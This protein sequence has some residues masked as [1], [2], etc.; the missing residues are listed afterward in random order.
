[1]PH[2]RRITWL[3][4]K[5]CNIHYGWQVCTLKRPQKAYKERINV[6]G[7]GFSWLR[8]E[9]E[10]MG[11]SFPKSSV[12]CMKCISSTK[13]HLEANPGQ[14]TDEQ[15]K[16]NL[17]EAETCSSGSSCGNVTVLIRGVY[18]PCKSTTTLLCLSSSCK[19]WVKN[20][21]KIITSRFS[22]YV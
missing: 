12:A 14:G 15:I 11:I 21:H 22:S 2:K 13:R 1:M 20:Y 10:R 18:F 7:E 3:Y 8:K 16:H 5:P 6:N 9:L 4:A 17:Y 19:I